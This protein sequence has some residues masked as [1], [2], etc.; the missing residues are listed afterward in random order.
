MLAENHDLYFAQ[1]LCSDL[2]NQLWALKNHLEL[3]FEYQFSILAVNL[4]VKKH[5]MLRSL[6]YMANFQA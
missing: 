3:K 5:Q 1:C 6:F 2:S 4:T